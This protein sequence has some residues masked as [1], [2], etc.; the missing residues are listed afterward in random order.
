MSGGF[1][2][3]KKHKEPSEAKPKL[4]PWLIGIIDDEPSMHDVTKLALSRITIFD[5]PLKFV[6]AYSAHEGY[7][8]IERHP[9]MAL[10]LLDVVM[11]TDDA[12]LCLVKRIR[13]E[14]S[15]KFIQIILRTGQPGFAPEE[16]VMVDYE[17]NA[18]KTKSELTRSKLF[19]ALATGIRSYRQ[20]TA[21]EKSR[22]GLRAIIEAS[23]NLIQERSVYDFASG[24]LDQI[25][26]L[27]ELNTESIFCVSQRPHNGPSAIS[28]RQSDEYFVV[29]ASEK[30]QPLFGKPISAIGQTG[31]SDAPIDIVKQVL[32]KKQ[33]IFSEQY[34]CLYLSTPSQWEG[35]IIAER[36]EKLKQVDQEL[37]QVFCMNV[38]IGL[39]NAKFFNYL[40]KAAYYD[41]VT[42]LFSRAG[43][44]DNART[45]YRSHGDELCLYLLDVDY[46]HNIIESLGYDFGNKIL[47][48]IARHLMASYGEDVVLA[49]LHSDVFAL[50]LPHSNIKAQE[51]AMRSSI[52]F[53]IDD[54]AIRLGMTVGA[55]KLEEG[56][57]IDEFDPSLL[58]R[59]AEIAL[60]VAKENRRGS[61]ELFD[62]NY[63][64][65]SRHRMSLLSDIRQAIDSKELYLVM[66][67]KVNSADLSI[68]GYEA[69]LRWEHELQ[70]N[71]PPDAF[72]PAVEKSG[73]YY[74]V[75]LYVAQ[76]TCD[77]INQNKQLSHPISINLSA[78]SLNHET[79]VED[80]H[81]VFIRNQVP[82]NRVEL[83]ITENA[84]IHS[85][86][87]IRELDR[88]A[89]Y[90]FTICLDD[91]GAGYSSLGY[92]LRLPLHTIK[93]DR[94]FVSHLEGN[95]KAQ[96]V[97]EGIINMGQK[98]GKEMI[99][100]GVETQAQLAL[101][102]E[103]GVE[104]IQGFYFFKPM[105]IEQ[106]LELQSQYKL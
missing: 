74:D 70:G 23:S 96:V 36:A 34:S 62:S 65:N 40:N 44:I 69:L 61:G 75:D 37:L 2:K 78:N 39:E 12:G 77:L 31:L 56:E 80:L 84:L 35:V 11:E 99:V 43:F 73:L 86:T 50:L 33:H 91:F 28:A 13:E 49:R 66:Q 68:M 51:V 83:E 48:R 58:L 32:Q 87:A 21:L 26:A 6:S 17:I 101:V 82:L 102:R 63:E 103:M 94:A 88:L 38:A 106:I 72:I 15:N 71:I 3:I 100:E 60:K 14:L 45:F 105:K 18:Y 24:V 8:L 97:L 90:G 67:P 85:E 7:E 46:F 4:D 9:E 30:Y 89:A 42:G 29:A 57:S 59:H 53:N 79:F 19:T 20:I 16:Q 25:S 41:E 81:N 1:L 93:I 54:H 76:A 55:A 27:F 22:Q 5:R 52:P 95:Q 10:V 104:H 92:L 47:K 64:R 98:L